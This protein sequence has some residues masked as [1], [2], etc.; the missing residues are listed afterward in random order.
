MNGL[1]I[2]QSDMHC[3]FCLGSLTPQNREKEAGR[4]AKWDLENIKRHIIS[5]H[6]EKGSIRK[7][8]LV[9]LITNKENMDPLANKLEPLPHS[10]CDNF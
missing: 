3:P 2:Y 4:A 9:D 8:V 7:E 5:Q 1:K 6:D 10:K